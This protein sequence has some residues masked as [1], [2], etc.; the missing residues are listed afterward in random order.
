MPEYRRPIAPGATFFFTVVTNFRRPILTSPAASGLLRTAFR[1]EPAHHPFEIDA[2]VILPDHL[3]CLWTLPPDDTRY[4]MRWSAIKGR[5]TDLFLAGGG[6]E[7]PRS[8]SRRKARA[9]RR[10][11]TPV[12][13]PRGWDRH[14]AGQSRAEWD[15]HLAGQPRHMDYIHYNPVKHGLVRCPHAWPH[16]SLA[17][18]VRQGTYAADWMCLCDG[19]RAKPPNFGDIEG[20]TGE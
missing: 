5:F 3:H 4:S 6:T 12:P 19:G 9:A 8:A 20:R 18:W 2:V 15:R 1:Q 7:T 13:G 14:P 10:L 16:S 11:A 17:K